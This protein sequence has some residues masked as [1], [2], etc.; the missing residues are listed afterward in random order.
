MYYVT[1]TDANGC[2]KTDSVLIN[3]PPPLTYNQVLSDYNGFNIT[4]YGKSDGSI[5]IN[6]TSGT[7]PYIFSW[8][9]PGGY[10]STSKDISGLR[11]GQYIMHITDSNLC[12][13]LDTIDLT[14]PGEIGM[15]IT[16]SLSTTAEHNINCAGG[17]TGTILVGVVNNAGPVHICGLMVR[18]EVNGQ[19]LVAGNYKVIITDSNGCSADSVITLTAPDS[20]RLSFPVTQPFCTDMPDGEITVN[21]YGWNQ[22]RLYIPLV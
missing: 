15:I 20:I 18:L 19:V 16:T 8:Q 17:K 14:E 7:P 13:V 2:L 1:V 6:P 9:G 11:T 4:C 10:S 5:Q 21:G 3:L 22:F 12:D